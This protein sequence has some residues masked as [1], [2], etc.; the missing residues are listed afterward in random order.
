MANNIFIDLNADLG[1][2]LENEKVLMPYLSSCN[3]ACGGHAGN[4]HTML[5]AVNLAKK[6][7]V[8]IGAHPSFPDRENFGRKLMVMRPEDLK[9]SLVKQVTT[10]L[11]IAGSQNAICHHVK[12]HGALYNLAARD[13][14][15]AQV[16]AEV[17]KQFG[18]GL[19]LYAPYESAMAK[20]AINHDIEVVLE[21]FADRNYN[22]DLGL[23]SRQ[24]PN[25]LITSPKLVLKHIKQIVLNQKV[26]TIDGVEVRLKAKTFC[27]HGDQ[28]NA[29]DILRY[30]S[31]NFPDNITITKLR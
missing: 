1:E 21:A 9:D 18:L 29:L 22:S 6:Y 20:V 27:I 15:L 7:N 2:G 3:I 26:K 19:K 8:K 23:V 16:I 30:L 24:S 28:E 25:A 5:S 17:V 14:S 4:E 12:P 31:L 11:T 13:E 10:F